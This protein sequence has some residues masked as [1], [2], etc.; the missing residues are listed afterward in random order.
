MHDLRCEAD[1]AESPK[2]VG[3]NQNLEHC[4][5][6]TKCN[7]QLRIYTVVRNRRSI[8]KES[9]DMLLRIALQQVAK[10]FVFSGSG[11]VIQLP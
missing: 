10:A 6:K 8:L 1:C 7:F 4:S 2:G 5:R 11:T 3:N 9:K